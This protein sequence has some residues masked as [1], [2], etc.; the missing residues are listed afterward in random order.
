MCRAPAPR[1]AAHLVPEEA[2]RPRTKALRGE[3][4]RLLHLKSRFTALLLSLRR[5]G[6]PDALTNP[7]SLELHGVF[8][9]IPERRPRPARR[10]VERDAQP[11]RHTHTA[12]QRGAVRSGRRVHE[13]RVHQQQVARLHLGEAGSVAKESRS[14]S[15]SARMV[16]TYS[17]VRASHLAR[18]LHH[19]RGATRAQLGERNLLWAD[20]SAAAQ[21]SRDGTVRAA[22]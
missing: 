1:L 12:L 4:A 10:E 11:I 3:V 14:T 5:A 20:A 16:R 8:A 2:Q 7:Y 18:R 21:Q 17:V 6:D 22:Q 15:P 13:E 19:R 9:A